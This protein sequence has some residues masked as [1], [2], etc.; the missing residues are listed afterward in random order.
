MDKLVTLG[1]NN[2][3]NASTDSAPSDSGWPGGRLVTPNYVWG[4]A[5]AAHQGDPQPRS[6]PAVLM[7]APPRGDCFGGAGPTL[8]T[9]LEAA[10]SVL[11]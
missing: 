7:V 11:C 3:S 6:L 9:R 1:L 8:A 10:V 4:R 5:L 2:V